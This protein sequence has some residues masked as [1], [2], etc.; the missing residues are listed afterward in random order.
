MHVLVYEQWSR[1]VLFGAPPFLLPVLACWRKRENHSRTSPLCFSIFF[2]GGSNFLQHFQRYAKSA[3]NRGCEFYNDN[4]FKW[5]CTHSRFLFCLIITSSSGVSTSTWRLHTLVISPMYWRVNTPVFVIC[6][7]LSLQTG[8]IRTHC[9]HC[10]LPS[11]V[12]MPGDP[13]VHCFHHKEGTF[14]RVCHWPT[15]LQQSDCNVNVVQCLRKVHYQDPVVWSPRDWATSSHMWKE[16]SRHL[17][18][19][20]WKRKCFR[21]KFRQFTS[22]SIRNL[23][24]LC[25]CM[26]GLYHGGSSNLSSLVRSSSWYA[27]HCFPDILKQELASFY[28]IQY[29]MPNTIELQST[30][31]NLMTQSD[32]LW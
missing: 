15:T 29:N 22:A 13:C 8:R 6:D 2:V 24:Q 31:L 25:T 4:Q 20:A 16:L 11:M 3:T 9:K 18:R 30:D 7:H 12:V 23:F 32:K 19:R 27:N 1:I 5:Q 21:I 14:C 17:H 26:I 10:R 28:C